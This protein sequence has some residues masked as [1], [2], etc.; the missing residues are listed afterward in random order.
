[1]SAKN[2]KELDAKLMDFDGDRYDIVVLASMWAKQ[3]RKK[4]EYKRQPHAVVIKVALDDILSGR[5]SKEDVLHVSKDNLEKE[6]KA[7]EE[8][9]LEAERK[10]KEPLKL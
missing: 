1:M 7:Q 10:A 5:V 2:E 4:N 9:R 8:A 6:M 3:L